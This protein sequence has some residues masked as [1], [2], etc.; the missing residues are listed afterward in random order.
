MVSLHGMFLLN[1]DNEF[2]KGWGRSG[3]S[4]PS[5]PGMADLLLPSS[6]L[7]PFPRNPKSPAS[8][9]PAQPLATSNFIYQSTLN[10]V[11]APQVC[12]GH[13]YLCAIWG[14]QINIL[15]VALDQTHYKKLSSAVIPWLWHF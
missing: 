15:Q 7:S 6:F 12:M 1:R 10:G 14:T 5:P 4:F 2:F 3:L 8:V 11:R 13:V 9:C